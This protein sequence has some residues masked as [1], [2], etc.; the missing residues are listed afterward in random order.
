VNE[1]IAGYKDRKRHDMQMTK[2]R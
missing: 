1:G 2:K